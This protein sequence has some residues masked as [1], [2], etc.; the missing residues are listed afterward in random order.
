M[1]LAERPDS[2]DLGRTRHAVLAVAAD[3]RG[4]RERAESLA[5]AAH[6]A[7]LANVLNGLSEVV[8]HYEGVVES[9]TGAGGR[10]HT[11]VPSLAFTVTGRN[12]PSFFGV[13][14]SIR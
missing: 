8:A 11:T 9:V 3:L 2:L 1:E 14:G 4:S 5:P 6:T 10:G 13:R 7:V 12:V